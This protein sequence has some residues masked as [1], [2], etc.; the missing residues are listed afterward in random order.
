MAVTA[1]RD[2]ASLATAPSETETQKAI[3]THNMIRDHLEGDPALSR[4]SISTYLQGSY[5]NS[6]NVRGDSDVDMGSMS[7]DIFFY[8]L[9]DLPSEPVQLPYGAV[10][11]SLR[12]EVQESISSAS[13]SYRDY[14]RDVYASLQSKYGSVEDGNKAIRVD[15]NTYRLDG[16]VLPC[17]GFRMYYKH[18]LGNAAYH[19]GIAFLTSSGKRIVNF[20]KQHFDNLGRKDRE[21][22]HKVKGCVRIIKRLRNE[23]EDAGRW[24]RKRSP[25]FYLESLLYNVPNS[26]F[27]G[28]YPA[29]LQN[30]L[31][32][33]W[34]DLRD[35]QAKGN[36]DSYI[37]AND[38]YYL[39]HPEFW[40]A[41]DAL[42]FIDEIWKAAFTE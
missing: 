4:Y 7:E 31:A 12:E 23:L 16:D 3:R 37:Q 20:P 17:I 25:S 5:K 34:N 2:L 11:K 22:N 8:D 18:Y 14:R 19:E 42:A 6:T 36:L 28:G 40:N 33:L 41:D 38:I 30:V 26:Q 9:N 27:S 10:A 29:V 35:K 13:Y 21:N 15:G 39:F 1:K 32:H 24:D